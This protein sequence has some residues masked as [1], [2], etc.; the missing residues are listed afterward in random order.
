MRLTPLKITL[1]IGLGAVLVAALLPSPRRSI[2]GRMV[3]FCL[4]EPLDAQDRNDT[5]DKILSSGWEGELTLLAD[6]L[7]A[8]FEP[9]KNDLPKAFM[10]GGSIP[11]ERLPIQYRQL[12][13]LYSFSSPELVF[14]SGD[15]DSPT[16]I[17]IDWAH[18]RHAIIIY[19]VAPPEGPKGV[20]LR[21]VSDRI[22]VV[23]FEG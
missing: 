10:G 3:R 23:S 12:G 18:M 17:V 4:G 22:Y 19:A 16:Q 11:I 14:R 13:G 15:Q 8:E 20:R 1:L 6:K 21:K 9:V 7:I 2:P 5:A